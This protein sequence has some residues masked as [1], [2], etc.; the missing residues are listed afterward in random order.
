MIILFPKTAFTLAFLPSVLDFVAA[1][2][3]AARPMNK[4]DG[5]KGLCWFSFLQLAADV[6]NFGR[7]KRVEK[8]ATFERRK[9]EINKVFIILNFL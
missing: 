6:V 8:A 7:P 2:T 4:G 3:A 1:R 9:A 5:R